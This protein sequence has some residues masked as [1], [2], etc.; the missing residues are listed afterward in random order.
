M[1]SRK[2]SQKTNTAFE[3]RFVHY[4]FPNPTIIT[5]LDAVALNIFSAPPGHFRAARENSE[6]VAS[7]DYCVNGLRRVKAAAGHK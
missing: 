7:V 3:L 5:N 4:D 1:R 6:S 2:T